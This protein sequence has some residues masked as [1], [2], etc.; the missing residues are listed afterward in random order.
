MWAILRRM[1]YVYVKIMYWCFCCIFSE[2]CQCVRPIE[3]LCAS[4]D[5][6]LLHI[7]VISCSAMVDPW[8]SLCQKTH[9]LRLC[10]SQINAVYIFH[11]KM[12]GLWL[13]CYLSLDMK[14]YYD[15]ALPHVS[16]QAPNHTAL[17]SALIENSALQLVS[18]QNSQWKLHA[19][20][21]VMHLSDG[22]L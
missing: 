18:D 11:Q 21:Q 16:S 4:I 1:T 20:K 13:F 14:K 8:S 19:P 17:C 9:W 3:V 6:Y 2:K 10:V 22:N 7:C 5:C 12:A 15:T